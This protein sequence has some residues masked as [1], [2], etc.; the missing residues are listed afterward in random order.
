[1]IDIT[2]KWFFRIGEK[3]LILLFFILL[4]VF[5]LY[6]SGNTQYFLD[7]TQIMLL[8]IA[9]GAAIILFTSSIVYGSALVLSGAGRKKHL[10]GKYLFFLSSMLI[11]TAIFFLSKIILV[12]AG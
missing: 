8:D 2:R 10:T 9:V 4:F 5:T 3:I 7:S 6:I 12:W 1:M 11:S